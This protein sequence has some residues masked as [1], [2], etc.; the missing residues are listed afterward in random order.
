MAAIR[1]VPF[2]D[3]PVLITPALAPASPVCLHRAIHVSPS[4]NSAFRSPLNL[5]PL[6]FPVQIRAR[7]S[8]SLLAETKWVSKKRGSVPSLLIRRPLTTFTMQT[9][10]SRRHFIRALAALGMGWTTRTRAQLPVASLQISVDRDTWGIASPADITAVVQSAGEQIWVHCVHSQL[11]PI[12]VYHRKDYPVTDIL[13][14]WKGRISI[15]LASQ[16]TRWAQ[17]AFQFGHEFC[18]ALAQ[19]SAIGKRGWHNLRHANMWFEESL[20]ETGSLFALRRMAE[21]WKTAPPYPQWRGYAP[22]FSMYA[23]ARL[24]LPQHRL[25]ASVLFPAWFHDNEPSL[26]ASATLREKNTIIASQMLPVLEATPSGWE[27]LC[28]LNLGSRDAKKPFARHLTEWS[29]NAPLE[30]RPFVSR[31]AAVFN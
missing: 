3:A 11:D 16:D 24:G 17:F 23:A 21:N 13:R 10:F 6:I 20:C 26:R 7:A 2:V 25:P 9:P 28:Y 15:G 30:L 27:A 22:A 8:E 12:R 18:H 5:S 29:Q 14:D 19:H 31:I 4:L 1:R